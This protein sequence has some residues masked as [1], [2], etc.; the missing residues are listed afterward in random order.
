MK[1]MNQQKI[2]T[3]TIKSL[4]VGSYAWLSTISFGLVLL[5]M[6]YSGLVPVPS[7][8]L[9]EVADFLLFI[10]AFTVLAALGAIGSSMEKKASR[11]FLTASLAVII[12]GFT[13]HMVL[14]PN[15]ESGSPFGPVIR[16][17]LTGSASVLAFIGFYKY[18][19]DPYIMI[20]YD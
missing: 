11:N 7:T 1:T 3:T 19:G 15:L 20:S 5:D 4:I 18:C 2:S 14:S 8:A 13:L 12:L 16:I 17:I 10:N 6:L 9:R